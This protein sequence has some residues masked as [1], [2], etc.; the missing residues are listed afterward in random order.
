MQIHMYFK[1][2]KI[3]FLR[4]KDAKLISN[5]LISRLPLSLSLYCLKNGLGVNQK[6]DNQRCNIILRLKYKCMSYDGI[7]VKSD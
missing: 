4:L 3:C 7:F 2:C 1:V 5:W 6:I